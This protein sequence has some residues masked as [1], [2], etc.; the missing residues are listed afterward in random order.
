MKFYVYIIFSQSLDKFY[1]WFTGDNLE[2]R[3]RK[4]KTNH[5]GFTGKAADWSIVYTE[6]FNTKPE[7]QHREKLIKS[8]KSKRKIQEQTANIDK[9]ESES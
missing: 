7:A 1:V 6:I 9:T 5:K 3:L 2:E 4:H 8:W